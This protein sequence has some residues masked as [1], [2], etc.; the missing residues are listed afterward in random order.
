MQFIG[1]IVRE[2][3]ET[4]AL[5]DK[6][7]RLVLK[8]LRLI[9]EDEAGGLRSF[10]ERLEAAGYGESLAQ[11]RDLSKPLRQV[12]PVWVDEVLGSE[13]VSN[14][15]RDLGLANARVRA[16]LNVVIPSLVRF[17][18]REAGLPKA[19][20]PALVEWLQASAPASSASSRRRRPVRRRAIDSPNRW[21]WALGS[22]VLLASGFYLGWTILFKQA[23]DP[24]HVPDVSA[25]EPLPAAEPP[26]AIRPAAPLNVAEVTP[27]NRLVLRNN[28]QEIE[29]LGYLDSPATGQQILETL[30]TFFGSSRL[31]GEFVIEP[32]RKVAPWQGQLE[33]VLPQLNVPGLDVRLDGNTVRVGGWLSEE[34]RA[35]ILNSLM[36]TLGSDYRF[37]YLRDERIERSLDNYQWLAIK[38]KSV[39]PETRHQD[40]LTILNRWVIDFEEGSAV[41]PERAKESAEAVAAA[42]KTLRTPALIEVLVYIENGS[43]AQ[44]LASERAA[45]IREALA[46]GGYASALIKTR[47]VVENVP[48]SQSPLEHAQHNRVEF[49][50]IRLCDGLFPCEGSS[51][52]AVSP[53]PREVPAETQ[54]TDRPPPISGAPGPASQEI[55]ERRPA[56]APPA[57]GGDQPVVSEPAEPD[58]GAVGFEDRGSGPTPLKALRDGLPPP[59]KPRPK[60]SSPKPK[61]SPSAP[62]DS[63]WYDPFGLF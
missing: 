51:S 26:V 21:L 42:L 49:R 38:L 55:P 62:K 61:P 36:G 4:F 3:D 57:S 17:L 54:V 20:P 35:G 1:D 58:E 31:V 6:S 45:S 22:L 8:A 59:P 39:V 40:L 60:P 56:T 50:L 47:G 9:I 23:V 25:T 32:T 7:R 34:D 11:W 13:V 29:Y 44:R 43:K 2:A 48:A 19:I 63:E 12:D 16:V 30:K 53:E 27:G 28:G 24:T 18:S 14:F 33:R 37:G 5:G 52:R 46:R 10:F 41:F 15:G